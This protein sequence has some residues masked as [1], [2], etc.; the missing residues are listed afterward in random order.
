M[1]TIIRVVR[2]CA[3][4][5]AIAGLVSVANAETNLDFNNVSVT[6]EGA[7]SLSWNSTP[8]EYY[9]IDFADSLIDTNTGAITWKL[10]YEDYPSQGSST[11]WLDTGNY[12]V[13][14]VAV[15]PSKSPMRFYRIVLSGT[16]DIPGPSV[17]ITSPTG[18]FLVSDRINV[19][20]SASS[21]KLL[22]YTKLYVDGQEMQEA[23]NITNYVN[24]GTNYVLATYVLNTCEWP[25]G[26][27]FLFATA[28][29][30][31][32]PSGVHDVAAPLIGRATSSFVSGAF[33]N[34]ITS[35]A[36]S[37][38]FFMPEDGQTQHVSAV[39]AANVDWTLQIQDAS[40]NMVR[41]AAGSGG[42][43]AFD[44]N[45]KNNGGA[46]LPVGNYTYLISVQTNGQA[47]QS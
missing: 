33:S 7:I 4:F 11:V 38:P 20:V 32:G 25:N 13:D 45:G 22:I 8:K 16:N 1:S 26:P 36:F 42:T 24:N 44:W 47:L 21:D 23:N 39:F 2:S 19:S 40:S 5:T 31:S 34:L 37:Q 46:D 28:Q 14:P 15:H 17:A 27:H 10:L 9:E 35:V 18:S 3:V 6:A 41:S 43:L 30:D 29:C 12:F